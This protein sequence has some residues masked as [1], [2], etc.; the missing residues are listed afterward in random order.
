MREST[1]RML[2]D[3]AA[4]GVPATDVV[5]SLEMRKKLGNPARFAGLPVVTFDEWRRREA[6]AWL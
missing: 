3:M 4:L 6:G 2:D 5:M 1:Q